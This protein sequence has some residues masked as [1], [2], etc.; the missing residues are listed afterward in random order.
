MGESLILEVRD[1][2]VQLDD[3]DGWRL[4][5]MVVGEWEV[6]RNVG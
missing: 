3:G 4:D 6:L 1:S 2:L 5:E